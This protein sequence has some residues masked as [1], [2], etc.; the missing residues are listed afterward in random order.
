MGPPPS[1]ST[2]AFASAVAFGS[3][4][5]TLINWRCPACGKYLSKR[6]DPSSCPGCGV[7]FTD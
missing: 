5:Y 1:F 7:K 4:I 2:I 6:V 3:L